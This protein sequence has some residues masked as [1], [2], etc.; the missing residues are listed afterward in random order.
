MKLTLN[1]KCNCGSEIDIPIVNSDFVKDDELD[2]SESI[3]SMS[4]YRFY[5]SQRWSEA[6]DVLCVNCETKKTLYY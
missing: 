3:E 1:I 5:C 2:L 6:V 4:E